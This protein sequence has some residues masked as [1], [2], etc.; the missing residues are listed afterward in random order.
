MNDVYCT[1]GNLYIG[2]G[3]AYAASRDAMLSVETEDE[4]TGIN[5]VQARA[6]NA[7]WYTLSGVKVDKPTKRGIYIVNGR[8]VVVGK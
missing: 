6:D 7:Q 4:T 5:N 1:Y 2:G 3:S 8:K